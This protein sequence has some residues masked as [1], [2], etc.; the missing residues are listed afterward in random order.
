MENLRG[1]WGDG[2][3]D[4]W[5][6]ARN[7]LRTTRN[8]PRLDLVGFAY[9]HSLM[10]LTSPESMSMQIR[11]HRE[12]YVDNWATGGSYSKG[13]FPPE[14]SFANNMIPALVSQ[15]IEWVLVDNGHFDR[16]LNDFPWSAASSIKPNRAEQRNGSA[17]N[18][19]ST[20][21]QLNNVWAPTRVAAPWS[22]QPHYVRHVDPASGQVRKIIAVPAARYEGNENGRGGYGAFKPEN[23]WGS[24]IDKNNNPS[25]PMIIVA[26][27]DG[28]NFGM[29]NAD[30]FHGQHGLFL[31]M[32]QANPNFSH[33]TVQDYLDAYPPDSNDLIHVEPG[34]WVG[35][36]GGTPY[37]D[38][39][40]ENNAR[41]GQHPDYWSWSVLIA[42][43][44]RVL[45]ADNLE[46]QY[47]MNDVRWGI[48]SD[49]ARAWRY[50]LQAETSC[51][52]YWDYDTAN[53]WDGNA[54]RGA[55]LAIAE[56]NKVIARH[57][58]VDR[59][60]PS[61]FPPQRPIW[62]P[63]GTQWN[64]TDVQP[65]DFD[66]WTFVDDVSGVSAVRLHWRTADWDTWTDLT[67]TAHEIYAHT[68]GKNSPWNIVPMTSSWYPTAK[69]PN[70]PDPAARAMKYDA[71]VTG[72]SDTLINYFIEA[73]DSK[74]NTSRSEIFHVWVGADTGGGDGGS[75]GGGDTSPS[76]TLSP[77]QPIAGQSVTV[78]YN[79]ASRPLASATAVHIHHGIN[80]TLPAD[81]T[82][83]PGDSMTKDGALWKFTYTVPVTATTLLMVFNDGANG[84]DN[85]GGNNWSFSVSAQPAD[86]PAAP[87][88]LAAT[89]IAHN[90]INLA[91]T[92]VP[93]AT[94]YKI[95]RSATL[96]GTSTTASFPDTT[97]LATTT[98]SY[99]VVAVNSA[100]ESAPSASASATTL[101]Q[102]AVEDFDL[103][104]NAP[105]GF[106]LSSPG[107]K[108][109]AALRGTKLYVATWFASAENNNDHYLFIGNQRLPAATENAVI[110]W[111]KS[112][113]IALP[114]DSPYLAQE[115][116]NGWCG[117]FNA[118]G[119]NNRA[120]ASAQGNILE[121]VLD[122]VEAFGTLPDTLYIAAAAIQTLDADGGPAGNGTLTAQAPARKLDNGNI[123]PDE[124]LVIPIASIRDSAGSNKLDRL[125]PQ[126]GFR[127]NAIQPVPGGLVLEIPTV[128]GIRYQLLHKATL[129][130]PWSALG[131]P[132]EGLGTDNQSIPAIPPTPSTQGFFRLQAL[133]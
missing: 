95:L 54:S 70:V 21:T 72:Q 1:I 107:M 27:S 53:P 6:W 13:F 121:G 46:N 84:W 57:P 45:H 127:P 12:A 91:W 103:L 89:A 44:N 117:W 76:V 132:I 28:D 90:R 37:Y 120:S 68:P 74:G 86:P 105:G 88:G 30:A 133:E 40:I 116:A 64:N 4:H 114:A 22:Y 104:G 11:L 73:V 78:T 101:V 112:V 71:M 39:W 77:L 102:P 18:K 118:N 26:H 5:R 98:Y 82:T 75:G 32:I 131:D 50:F 14:S 110:G 128:P 96:L 65:S 85:N 15:G 24:H 108:I 106:R 51:H 94:S 125:D 23:V 41:D 129:A 55:N 20:W 61:I 2:W 122:L 48:G 31:N 43:Q 49:T 3:R 115:S 80:S 100:G 25:K 130:D 97:A 111:N 17:A 34:S 66:I 119:T 123:D 113:K 7:G 109:H 8:N 29:K 81:W 63:G 38:K 59:V 16:T 87:T 10:P 69:G 56:A 36:D 62:N 83:P 47:S 67:Q 93:G 52:W 92:A 126:R 60:G 79:P 42:A 33:T 35:I 9:H 99:T 19:N 58:S 124:L